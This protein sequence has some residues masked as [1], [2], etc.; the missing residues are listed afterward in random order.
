MKLMALNVRGVRHGWSFHFFGD[1][2]DLSDWRADGLTVYQVENLVPWWVPHW[3][4]KPFCWLQDRWNF[5]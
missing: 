1:P 3:A 5:K 4:I 2:A